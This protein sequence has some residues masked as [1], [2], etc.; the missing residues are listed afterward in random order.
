MYWRSILSR[1]ALTVQEFANYTLWNRRGLLTLA[2]AGLIG[3]CAAATARADETLK[4][5]QFMHATSAQSLDVGD[6]DG[7][8]MSLVRFTGLVSLPDGSVGTAYFTAATD[9]TKGAGPFSVYQNLTLDDGSVLWYKMAG[10][11]TVDGA[12]TLFVGTITV[13]GGKGRFEGAKGEGTVTGTRLNP[14]VVGAVL[15]LD[16][17]ITI[18]K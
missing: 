12:K 15:Y 6:V 10:T 9:Y 17:T 16:C 7:H 11:A 1:S 13:L 18:K 5:R 4:F 8:A 2:A 3:F 14:L